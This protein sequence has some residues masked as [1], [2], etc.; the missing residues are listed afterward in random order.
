MSESSEFNPHWTS[1]PGATITDLINI[2]NIEKTELANFINLGLRETDQLLRGD[3]VITV[4]IAELL[5]KH[6][7]G[8]SDFWLIRESNYRE[9]LIKIEQLKEK[10]SLTQWAKKFPVREMRKRGWLDDKLDS[11]ESILSFFSARSA[12]EWENIYSRKIAA[13]AFRASKKLDEDIYSTIAWI[14]QGEVCAEKITC[15]PWSKEILNDSISRLRNL[16]IIKDPLAYLPIVQKILAECGVAFVIEKT[17]TGCRVSG[18][19][20]FLSNNK[21]MI[22]QSGRYGTNDHFWFTL[23]HEIGH[24]ILHSSKSTFLDYDSLSN[25]HHP[26]EIEAN[27]FSQ[28]TLIPPHYQEQLINLQPNYRSILKFAKKI[29]IAP[30]I[31]VGQLQYR[32]LLP[33]HHLN[34]L[35]EKISIN[36]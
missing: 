10:E 12:E 24:L 1:S 26:H 28:N 34:K 15:R 25:Q 35:K 32:G 36:L 3:V 8:S 33:R 7:G 31:I 20:T 22:L 4:R 30:G 13:S 5:S 23:F 2:K 14:R 27:I 21:A 16:T 19:T 9:D 29:N 6:L 18:V 11:L 17:I